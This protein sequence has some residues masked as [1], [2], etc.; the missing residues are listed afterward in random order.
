MKSLHD[1]W[2]DYDKNDNQW[3]SYFIII[4]DNWLNIENMRNK[5]PQRE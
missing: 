2:G 4:I 5:L 3:D 1:K